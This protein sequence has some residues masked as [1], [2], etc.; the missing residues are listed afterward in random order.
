MTKAY[1]DNGPNA[2]TEANTGF[3]LFA[4]AV[5]VGAIAVAVGLLSIKSGAQACPA[6]RGQRWNAG[7]PPGDEGGRLGQLCC[8]WD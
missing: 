8:S 7:S 1:A 2:T 6:R 4:G 3:A 5:A